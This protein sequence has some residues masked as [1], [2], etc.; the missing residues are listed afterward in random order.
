MT[1]GAAGTHVAAA[2]LAI[3]IL[4]GALGL[5]ATLVWWERSDQ[6]V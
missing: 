6:T 3:V 5:A 4:T 2:S 1:S